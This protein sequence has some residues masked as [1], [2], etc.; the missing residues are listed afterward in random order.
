MNDFIKKIV[1]SN[2][3][4]IVAHR[5]YLHEN[6]ELSECEYNTSKY[7]EEFLKK[8]GIEYRKVADTGIYAYIKNGEGK[9]VAFRADMDA[10]PILEESDFEIHSKNKGVMHA[11]GHDIHTSVQLGVAKILSENLDK[12][13]GNVKFFFQPAEETVGG[14]KRMLEDR[15]NDDFKADAIFAFHVAPEI[16]AG[17]IGVKYGKLHATSSTF[18]I[19]VNGFSAHAALAYLGID[20]VV[21]GAKVVEYLQSIVSRRIDARECAV[22]TVGTFNAGTAQNIVADKAVLTGTIRTLTLDLKKW[23]V[24]EIKTNLP[25]FVES[26]GA[27]VDID[28]KDSY[29]P[30]IN[31]DEK[32]KFLEEK[33]IDILGIDNVERIEKSRMDAE[34]VGYFLD[35]IEGSFYRLG[36][37]NEKIGAIYDLHH[38][39]FKVDENAIKVGMVVQLK[40]ALEFLNEN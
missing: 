17:K 19:T 25:K 26:M 20:T 3:D 28:F 23:I 1:D 14:A 10:L 22:I 13:K 35:V 11:C 34:D 32:T 40:S 5:R 29:I 4:E 24:N 31:N 30:V 39:K 2:Y 27:T 37:R 18:T 21:V 8:Q 6:P 15:V 33:A 38:P 16:D 12:W 36:V 7:I 9:T